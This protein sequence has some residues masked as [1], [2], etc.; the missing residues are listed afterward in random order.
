MRVFKGLARPQEKKMLLIEKYRGV[1]RWPTLTKLSRVRLKAAEQK[2]VLRQFFNE[3]VDIVLVQI[4][5]SI[6]LL[7]SPF[8]EVLTF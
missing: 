4:I 5:T 8:F 7:M 1:S 6:F 2:I 3:L